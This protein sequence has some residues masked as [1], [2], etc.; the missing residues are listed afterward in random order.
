MT[1]NLPNLGIF[2]IQFDVHTRSISFVQFPVDGDGCHE[3]ILGM[4]RAGTGKT[5][6]Y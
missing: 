1:T 3:R 5:I 2:D 6:V 4:I